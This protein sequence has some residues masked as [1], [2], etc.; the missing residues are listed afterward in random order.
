A[1]G[2]RIARRAPGLTARVTPATRRM[3]PNSRPTP[4]KRRIG[5]AD[6]VGSGAALTPSVSVLHVSGAEVH[7]CF[8]SNPG[9]RRLLGASWVGPARRRRRRA[10]EATERLV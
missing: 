9:R 10:E 5:A 6:S 4:R 8:V 1:V 3:T 7:R 2:P